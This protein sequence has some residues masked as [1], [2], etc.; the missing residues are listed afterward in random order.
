MKLL[1]AQIFY[2]ITSGF[3]FW[4]LCISSFSL[5][6]NPTWGLC[7]AINMNLCPFHNFFFTEVLSFYK[8]F[9]HFEYK[10]KKTLC[11]KFFKM[12]TENSQHIPQWWSLEEELWPEVCLFAF[13]IQAITLSFAFG[14]EKFWFLLQPNSGNICALNNS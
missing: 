2:I 8:C 13:Q 6:L 14:F 4:W 5:K 7:Q 10:K 9:S 3:V 1:V 12:G 11:L